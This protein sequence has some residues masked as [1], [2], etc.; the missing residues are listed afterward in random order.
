MLGKTHMAVGVA[1]G[2]T[3]M[4]PHNIQ[5]LVV[6]TGTLVIGSVI[7]DIDIGTSDSH[8]DA[9]KII[10]LACLACIAVAVVESTMHLGIY[11]RLMR[12]SSLRR[13][14]IGAAAFLVLCAF[15]KEQ[16]HRSFMHSV[17]A[18][19]L[20]TGCVEI[21]FPLAKPYFMIGFVSHLV[22]DLFNRRDERLLYPLKWGWS[23]GLCSSKGLANRTLFSVG[24][25]ASILIFAVLLS[26]IYDI[27]QLLHFL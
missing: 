16:P 6:G 4:H 5:E 17:P 27:R 10:A 14:V 23:L 26:Q 15:G 3:I 19:L 20:L 25:A 1:A 13:I 18:L 2:L 9:N 21:I 7:S 11:G 8:K 22:L 12:N 24:S